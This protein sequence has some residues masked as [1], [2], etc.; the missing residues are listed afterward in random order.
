MYFFIATAVR[1]SWDLTI[2]V[3][4]TVSRKSQ[5]FVPLFENCV[6]VIIDNYAK[7]ITPYHFRTNSG[8]LEVTK[9]YPRGTSNPHLVELKTFTNNLLVVERNIDDKPSFDVSILPFDTTTTTTT[10]LAVIMW[11]DYRMNLQLLTGRL[12]STTPVFF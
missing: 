5:T 11:F 12:L 9:L 1:H 4:C 3:Q 10:H 7:L 8:S 2:A 6:A